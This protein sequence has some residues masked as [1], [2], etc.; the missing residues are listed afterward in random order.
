[1]TSVE[2]S[3]ES[4]EKAKSEAQTLTDHLIRFV[5]KLEA[6]VPYY[7]FTDSNEPYITLTN[8]VRVL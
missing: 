5:L 8:I 6:I 3:A 1:M 4:F 2:V 7:E